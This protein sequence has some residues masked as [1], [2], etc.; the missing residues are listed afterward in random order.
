VPPAI[1]QR[2]APSSRAELL[3][4]VVS[5]YDRLKT[6]T[7]TIGGVTRTFYRCFRVVSKYVRLL[8]PDERRRIWSGGAGS[9]VTGVA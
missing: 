5:D 7:L 9:Y 1:S 6:E 3:L 4:Q 2:A 8:A